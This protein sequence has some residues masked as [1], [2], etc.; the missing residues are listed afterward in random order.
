P[1]AVAYQSRERLVVAGWFRAEAHSD[2]LFVLRTNANGQLDANFGTLGFADPS[3]DSRVYPEDVA[4]DS[5][6]RIVV[7]GSHPGG[8][9]DQ[10]IVLRFLPDGAPDTSFGSNGELTFPLGS[11]DAGA[12]S[13]ALRE[14]DSIVIGGWKSASHTPW[15]H[16]RDRFMLASVTQSGMLDPAFG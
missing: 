11:H 6:D 14:D 10:P 13:V 7:V 3:D 4:V 2:S 16:A 1:T 5:Q 9:V 8:S 12:T 15:R